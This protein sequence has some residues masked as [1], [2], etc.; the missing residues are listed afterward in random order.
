M[1][2]CPPNRE[3]LESKSDLPYG[4]A[5]KREPGVVVVVPPKRLP[6]V[7]VE[8]PPKSDP[9]FGGLLTLPKSEP[10]LVA[11]PKRLPY[12]GAVKG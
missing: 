1:F 8:A 10:E 5:P 9:C 11:P 6:V 3:F 2:P 7:V 4:A 12:F